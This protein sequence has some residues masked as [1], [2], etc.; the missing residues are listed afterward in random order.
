APPPATLSLH[1]A[2]PISRRELFQR[3]PPRDRVLA[4]RHHGLV[5]IRVARPHRRYSDP[6]AEGNGNGKLTAKE[7]KTDQEVRWCPGCGDY[8]SE[9]HTSELQSPCNL[10]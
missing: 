4:Q 5:P 6:V 9:E 8:R 1:D 7:F 2:L 3:Q 10:V